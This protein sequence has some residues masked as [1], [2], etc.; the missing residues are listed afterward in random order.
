MLSSLFQKEI[1]LYLCAAAMCLQWLCLRS[2]R[3]KNE[4]D[5]T[6]ALQGG[7]SPVWALVWTANAP[8]YLFVKGLV[9]RAVPGG[10]EPLKEGPSW[11]LGV[12]ETLCLVFS[13]TFGFSLPC[14]PTRMCCL[15]TDPK[16]QSSQSWN[17]ASNTVNQKKLSLLI[18]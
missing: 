17:E 14:S 3:C 13:F 4:K 16:Q 18:S 5:V 15:T 12:I 10:M 1:A 6:A 9:P 2:R 11:R 7:P 8:K